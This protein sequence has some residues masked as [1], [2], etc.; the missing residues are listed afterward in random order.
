M[1]KLSDYNLVR[2]KI[3][4]RKNKKYQAIIKNKKTGKIVNI[5]FGSS[6]HEHYRDS[7]LG[8]YKHLDHNDKKRRANYRK[9]HRNDKLNEYSAGYFSWNYLW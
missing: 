1:Y 4:P 3:S 5:H 7:A 9:R 6:L 2:F 8:A